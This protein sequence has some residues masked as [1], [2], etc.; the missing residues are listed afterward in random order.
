M[1]VC[2]VLAKRESS[3]SSEPTWKGLGE[4]FPLSTDENTAHTARTHCFQF[5][6][7][8]ALL[9]PELVVGGI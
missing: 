4:A 5:K 6:G 8:I 7:T 9:G 3:V 1:S 2:R